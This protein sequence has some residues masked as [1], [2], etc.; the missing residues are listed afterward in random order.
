MQQAIVLD[1]LLPLP[2]NIN[3]G[4]YL[5]LVGTHRLPPHVALI[6]QGL[7]FAQTVKGPQIGRQAADVIQVL[8]NRQIP[9]LL[10]RLKSSSTST[11]PNNFFAGLEPLE[12]GHSC[13][14]PIVDY[15]KHALNLEVKQPYLHGLLQAL[16]DAE[17][18]GETFALPMPE[19]AQFTLEPY[20]K[21]R[22]DWRISNLQKR[23]NP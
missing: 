11:A 8:Q 14:E 18:L 5:A 16:I 6:H 15:L 20:G 10:L 22:I 17:L 23:A 21:E 2:E 9:F 12:M 19:N 7:Y 13:V 3:D 1:S 4:L